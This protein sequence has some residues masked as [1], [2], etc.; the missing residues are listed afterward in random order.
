MS[1]TKRDKRFKSEVVTHRISLSIHQDT[2]GT[3][4]LVILLLVLTV[5]L[6]AATLPVVCVKNRLTDNRIGCVGREDNDD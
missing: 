2:R 3:T 6:R 4:R 1:S 5:A